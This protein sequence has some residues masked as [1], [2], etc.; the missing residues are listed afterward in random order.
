MR[1]EEGG[2][3]ECGVGAGAAAVPTGAVLALIS[4]KSPVQSCVGLGRVV[5][6]CDMVH[7]YSG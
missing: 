5:L 4:G 1:R 6:C 3:D 2:H 7:W